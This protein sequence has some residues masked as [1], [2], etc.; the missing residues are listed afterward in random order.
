[1]SKKFQMPSGPEVTSSFM[2]TFISALHESYWIFLE[3]LG[4]IHT[5]GAPDEKHCRPVRTEGSTR[6]AGNLE[7]Q[8]WRA[9]GR[10]LRE[11]TSER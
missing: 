11:M 7:Y 4:Q 6:Y 10:V 3:V 9:G 5:L 1:M 8:T 2:S